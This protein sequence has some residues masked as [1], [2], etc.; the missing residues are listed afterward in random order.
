MKKKYVV[1]LSAGLL[2]LILVFSTA[3]IVTEDEILKISRLFGLL[4]D[5]IKELIRNRQMAAV[6]HDIDDAEMYFYEMTSRALDE[7]EDGYEVK[8]LDLK[9]IF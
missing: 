2:L 5:T 6:R 7:C 3:Y 1:L 9:T 8:K 4:E